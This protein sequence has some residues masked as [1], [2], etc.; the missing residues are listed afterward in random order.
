MLKEVL[1]QF[2]QKVNLMLLVFFGTVSWSLTMIKSGWNYSYGMGFWGPNGHDGVWHIALSESLARGSFEMPVF[3]GQPLQNYHIGFDLFLAFLHKISAIPVVNLYFQILPP[4]FAIAIGILVYRLVLIW[5]HSKTAAWWSTFFVYFGGSI[6]WILGKGE[7]AFWSQQAISTLVNPPF[8]LSL[9]VVLTGLIYVVKK[10]FR[11]KVRDIVAISILFGLLFQIKVYA[12]LLV[13]GGLFV[14]GIFSLITKQQSSIIKVFVGTLLV[15]LVMFLPFNKLSAGMLVFQ[16]F[17]F[18]ETMMGLSDRINWQRFA[19]AMVNYKTGGV[20]IKAVSAYSVAFLIF[21]IG[22]MGTRILGLWWTV[23]SKWWKKDGLIEVF[24]ISI[25]LAGFVIPTLFLQKG[26]PWNTIQFFYYSLFFLS[27]LAGVFMGD[28]L[29]NLWKNSQNSLKP[30]LKTK[31]L[32]SNLVLGLVIITIPTTV[33]TLRDVYIPSRP[34]AKISVDELSALKFLSNQPIGVVLTFPFDESAAKNAED[35][36]PRPLYLYVSTAYVSAFSKQPVF[37][38]DEINLDITGYDWRVRREQ[39][40]RWYGETNEEKAR[41]FLSEN[42]IKYIYWLKG[43]R[44][45]F[46]EGQLGLTNIFENSEVVIYS[47]R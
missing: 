8:A 29:G 43:Q 5:V 2:Y 45:Y 44:A 26:T 31:L 7:S 14:T 30:R 15:S 20:W 9:I 17:W 16:P 4:V 39:V 40:G 32:Y 1:R 10:Q 13:L 12:G 46:G 37:L 18:L 42:N 6:A 21:L 36:P 27:I 19:T 34:P 41:S 23:R 47:T 24:L 35:S 22:N 28:L 33:I 3:A 25:I 38:E 11:L